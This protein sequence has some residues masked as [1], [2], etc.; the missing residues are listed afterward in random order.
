MTTHDASAYRQG[1]LGDDSEVWNALEVLD[2]SRARYYAS[3]GRGV[4]IGVMEGLER[5][6]LYLARVPPCIAGEGGR[7]AF[8]SAVCAMVRGFMLHP[9][10]AEPLLHAWNAGN[11]P[12]FSSNE[13]TATVWRCHRT[14]D[15]DYPMGYLLNAPE[16]AR[17]PFRYH[18]P[19]EEGGSGLGNSRATKTTRV[20]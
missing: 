7:P 17:V 12:P 8:W 13:L 3:T 14:H 11:C 16:G 10:D 18:P 1:L 5:A 19:G 2:R 6:R 15:T 9:R 20:E 4:T